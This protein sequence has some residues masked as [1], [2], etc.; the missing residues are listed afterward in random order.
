MI[1][2]ILF[3][4]FIVFQL[5]SCTTNPKINKVGLE[6]F[7]YSFASVNP[8][9]AAN[10]LTA[11][12]S[13]KNFGLTDYKSYLNNMNDDLAKDVKENLQIFS[14]IEISEIRNGYVI[15]I[16]STDL[17]I[18]FCDNSKCSGLEEKQVGSPDQFKNITKK[19]KDIS[20]T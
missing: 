9:I 11:T 3:L 1:K 18:G 16:F 10:H 12:G 8:S 14:I 13:F 6:R 5:G 17:K 2:N 20:C 15:C 4:V 7:A 19:L